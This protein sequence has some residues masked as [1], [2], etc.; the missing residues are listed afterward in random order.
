MLETVLRDQCGLDPNRPVLAGVSGGPD[1]L[2]LLDI[3]RTAGYRVIL[4]HFNH[5]L[6]PEAGQEADSVSNL[7]RS[8]GLPFAGACA[9]VRAYAGAHRLSLEEAARMLRYQFLFASAR[10]YE[11][12]AVAVGHTADDQ[13]ETV[14][15]HFLRGA[16]LAGLKGMEYRTLLPV[17]D[18]Q[19][20]LVRPL[21]SLWRA[22]TEAYCREHALQPHYDV[23]NT[24][25]A[26]FRN[27]LRHA[28][29]P[30]L[31][32]YNPRVKESVWHTAQ[33][34]QGDYSALQEVLEA[35]WKSIVIDTGPDWV[36]FDQAG[37]ARLSTGMR[38]NLICRA[39][40]SLRPDS[41]DFGFAA[42]E[43]AAAFA[44]VPAGRQI[45]FING[46]YLFAEG[47]KITLAAYE[48]DF[49][50]TQ[51]PQVVQASRIGIGLMT[52]SGQRLEL[53]NGWFLSAEYSLPVKD[54]WQKNTDNWS[55][56]L[57]ADML[58]A[59]DLEIRPRRAGD[60][61]S[62]LGMGGQTVRVQDFYTN[63]K[64]PRRARRRWPLVCAGEQIA[65]VAG[66]RIAHPFRITEKTRQILHLQI[67]RLTPVLH[68]AD[69]L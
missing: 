28:L 39:A 57:D 13:V 12:Q 63:V 52:D 4:A 2:C 27:R 31:E 68:Q 40:E 9:D 11:A 61:F 26:F 19:I 44:V 69:P 30:E 36:V 17:F 22:D 62:P 38:R 58:P 47:G 45:D 60:V 10:K 24:D 49:E 32:K 55:A 21:L 29:L 56:W 8:L 41:R 1:S 34:L 23:S 43:R 66:F 35:T 64:I 67:K 6:R 25:Q 54:D 3:L 33:A 48:A 5:Q 46:L 51:W 16:G 15:M 18:Q 37:L 53:G 7:A 42:L 14:L 20:P 59:G 50:Y 65:W